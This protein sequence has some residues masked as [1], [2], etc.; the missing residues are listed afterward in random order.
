MADATAK[1]LA[2]LDT[3]IKGVS[4]FQDL[5]EQAMER[6]LVGFRLSEN[7]DEYF[8]E[9]ETMNGL[10]RLTGGPE[11]DDVFIHFSQD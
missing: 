1:D 6:H 11:A 9:V 10:A 8:T 3:L 4:L 2:V 7:P 5:M